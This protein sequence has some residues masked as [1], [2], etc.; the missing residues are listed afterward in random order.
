MRQL[1]VRQRAGAD[2]GLRRRRLQAGAGPHTRGLTV[3]RRLVQATAVR[4]SHSSYYYYYY[5]AELSA[6]LQQ[7]VFGLVSYA[8]FYA[9]MFSNRLII[10][11][12]PRWLVVHGRYDEVSRLLRIICRVNNRCL[13]KDFKPACLLVEVSVVYQL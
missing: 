12:S 9:S 4:R 2:A 8:K 5:Y 11:E 13:P 6:V 3:E 10:P 1:R 7:A